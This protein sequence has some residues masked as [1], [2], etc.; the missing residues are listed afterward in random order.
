MAYPTNSEKRYRGRERCV[1]G[2]LNLVSCANTSK[3]KRICMHLFPHK[4]TDLQR[5]QNGLILCANVDRVF[6]LLRPRVF[7]QPTTLQL[8]VRELWLITSVCNSWLKSHYAM[9][10][11]TLYNLHTLYKLNISTKNTVT[12]ILPHKILCHGHFTFFRMSQ[13]KAF[14][15]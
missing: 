12:R 4:E 7:V 2:S 6:M 10:S 14:K 13:R 8:N 1:A 15:S 9:W 3:I 11:H 5:R